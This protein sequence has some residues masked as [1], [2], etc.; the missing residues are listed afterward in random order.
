ML[1]AG[2]AATPAL[3]GADYFFMYRQYLE[4]GDAFAST[5]AHSG[6]DRI[7][8]SSDHTTCPGV[9]QGYAGYTSSP[10]GGS[11]FTAY[12]ACGPGRSNWYPAGTERYY[13]HGAVVNPNVR[14]H[15]FVYYADYYW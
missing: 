4:D 7:F 5:S 9:A 2:A 13:F 8:K 10:N 14:T 11:H 15:S 6:V 12:S 3:A 1:F